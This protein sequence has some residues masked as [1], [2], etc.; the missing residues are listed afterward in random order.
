MMMN[1]SFI[2]FVILLFFITSSYAQQDIKNHY[3]LLENE[4]SSPLNYIKQ[5]FDVLHYNATIDL[6]KAPNRDTKGICE[7]IIYWRDKSENNKFFFHLRGLKVDSTFYE[8]IKV[9]AQPVE[10]PS[11][12]IYHYEILP[13]NQINKDTVKIKI[14]FSGRMT[15]EPMTN[16]NPW[17]GV[18]SY[19]DLLFAIGV[20]MYNNYVSTTQHWLPCYDHPSDKA[21]FDFKFIVK[22]GKKVASNGNVKVYYLDNGTDIY[23]FYSDI[24]CATYL[25]TF[26]VADFI[27]ENYTYQQIPIQIFYLP[28]DS[29]YTKFSLNK[30]NQMIQTFQD[31]FGPYPF[32]KVGYVVTPVGSM[33]HQ[34][35]IFLDDNTVRDYYQNKDTLC[36]TVAHELAHQWFGDLV[37]PYDFRDVWLN[38]SFATYCENLWIEKNTDYLG[39]LDYLS[40]KINVYFKDIVPYE[41]VLPLYYFQKFSTSSNYPWTIYNKGSAIVALL[42]YHLGDSLFFKSIK[43][44]LIKFAYN[45]ASTDDLMNTINSVSNENYSWFFE[46]WVFNPEYPMIKVFYNKK[47]DFEKQYLRILQTGQRIF[48]NLPVEVTFINNQGEKTNRVFSTSSQDT[49]FKDSIPDADY[50]LVN[51]GETIRTLM[52]VEDVIVTDYNEQYND[53]N[54]DIDIFFNYLNK[55]ITINFNTIPYQSSYQIIDLLGRSV[56]EVNNQSLLN[57]SSFN[58]DFSSLSSGIYL[59]KIIYNNKSIFRTFFVNSY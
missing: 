19:S 27:E 28:K 2:H 6:T 43:E 8:D 55:T 41:G 42:R 22:A 29:V 1:K 51:Q 20:G 21:T 23:E 46:Q 38:E 34:T 50:I 5:P 26:A 56:I 3:T 16:Y 33:E 47:S 4:I 15:A 48:K 10:I 45:N 25:M 44:Y 54:T 7:I 58:V 35:M 49:I 31:K 30:L 59:F 11:S 57:C 12:A 52:K 39:Y 24:P 9:I 32:E 17:G 18:H 53:K 40:Q 13:P 14:F 36:V 37:T